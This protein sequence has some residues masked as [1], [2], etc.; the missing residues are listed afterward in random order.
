MAP[1][2]SLKDHEFHYLRDF[3]RKHSAIVT[4]P[5]AQSSMELKLIAFMRA[6]KIDAL[7]SLLHTLRT[8]PRSP[9]TENFLDHMTNNE[10]LFFRDPAFFD[11]IETGIIPAMLERRRTTRALKIWSAASSSGQ[12]I[13]SLL[14]LL[15]TRFPELDRWDLEVMGS[16]ISETMLSRCREGLYSDLEVRRGLPVGYKE[17]FFTPEGRRWR[18]K[19]HVRK[20]VTFRKINLSIAWPRLPQFDIIL[21]RNV[22]IYFDQATKQAILRRIRYTLASDG[23][24]ALGGGETALT[25]DDSLER[26]RF[27]TTFVFQKK[28]FLAQ[29]G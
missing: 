10:T 26:V 23:L 21:L 7:S 27:G 20:M 19:A 15:Q 14:M 1:S 2:V 18:V 12:E 4:A 29:A 22:L 9:V 24:L 11:A 16:D 28:S 6:Q 5:D 25:L 8:Q 13:Y 3:V 17:R